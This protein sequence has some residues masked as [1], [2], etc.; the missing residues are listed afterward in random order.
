[1]KA[2]GGPAGRETALSGNSRI[3]SPARSAAFEILRRVEDDDAYASVLLAAS[4]DDI[5]ADDRA[6]CY[7][8]V[9]GVLR[10]QLWLDALIDHYAERKAESL[11]KPIRRALRMGLYE[12]RFL[13]RIPNSAT[14][15]ETVN[16]AYVARMRSASGFVN[17][18]LRRAIREKDY[19]PADQ[20][21]DPVLRLS[22]ATSHPAW[23]IERWVKALGIQEAENFARSNNEAPPVSFRVIGGH[24]EVQAVF[25]TLREAGALVSRSMIARDGWRVDGAAATVRMLATEGRIYLQDEASQLV[26]LVLEAEGCKS[27]LDVCAAPGS[28]TT[29]IASLA[30]ESAFIIGGD[31]YEHR[32]RTVRETIIRVHAKRVSLLIHDA[33]VNLPFRD[34]S[35]ER[36]LVD[37]PCSGTGTLRRNPEIRWRISAQDIFDMA[38]RQGRILANATRVL[39]PGGRLVYSTCSIEPEENEDVVSAFL[40]DHRDFRQVEVNVDATLL[41]K[42]GSVRTWTHRDGTDGFFI[43]ALERCG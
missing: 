41:R 39:R 14:V 3:V 40:Q 19:D 42:D 5:R 11:D 21:A 4:D 29:H 16:L 43:A 12:L 9:M 10:W 36:V 24:E 1:M 32:L 23:L 35:F 6:L 27:I 17:A 8:L 34:E 37:A 22:V 31:L 18:V 26:S 7:E 20:I 38:E 28:K 33:T 13:S 2:R 25:S 30:P 15:N